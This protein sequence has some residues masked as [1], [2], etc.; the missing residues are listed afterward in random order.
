MVTVTVDGRGMICESPAAVIG[1][2]LPLQDCVS[3]SE[4]DALTGTLD[5]IQT[6]VVENAPALLRTYLDGTGRGSLG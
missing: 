3:D 4:F 6:Y 2:V 5:A 1:T